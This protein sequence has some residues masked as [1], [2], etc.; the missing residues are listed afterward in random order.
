MQRRAL[1]SLFCPV[2]I[3][4]PLAHDPMTC[5]GNMWCHVQWMEAIKREASSNSGSG[6]KKSKRQV[7]ISTFKNGKWNLIRSTKLFCG[8]DAMLTKVGCWLIRCGVMFARKMEV[9]YMG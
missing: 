4:L 6:A 3:L 8:F 5:V 9:A 2:C 1:F 7:L